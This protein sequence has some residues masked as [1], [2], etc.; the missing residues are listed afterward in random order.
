VSFDQ[1][2]KNG[3]G[4]ISRDEAR[5]VDGLNFRSADTNDDDSLSR[6]EFQVAMSGRQP[7]G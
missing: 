6:Q 5:D 4:R 3:D 2:D 7:R 1:A